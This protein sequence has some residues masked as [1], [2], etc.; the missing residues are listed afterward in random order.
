MLSFLFLIK[1]VKLVLN[2]RFNFS[3]WP[4][5]SKNIGKKLKKLRNIEK[6][7]E[8]LKH[9]K[10]W[11]IFQYIDSETLNSIQCQCWKKTLKTYSMLMS[12]SIFS[13][14][15]CLS[16]CSMSICRPLI[17]IYPCNAL[18]VFISSWILIDLIF[19]PLRS[20][21]DR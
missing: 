11:A 10:H 17:Q 20:K 15:Q 1:R 9:W 3:F 4:K 7:W 13:M 19:Y 18:N 2:L 16:Q 14:F 21:T 8:T 5:I 12:M 6:H